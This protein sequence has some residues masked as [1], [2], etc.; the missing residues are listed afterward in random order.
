MLCV[1]S[2]ISRKV[3]IIYFYINV[4]YPPVV[5]VVG[6]MISGLTVGITRPKGLIGGGLNATLVLGALSKGLRTLIAAFSYNK[7][8]NNEVD[9]DTNKINFIIIS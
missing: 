1:I 6:V 5:A 4:Y 9:V 2:L 3:N 8:D 7:K